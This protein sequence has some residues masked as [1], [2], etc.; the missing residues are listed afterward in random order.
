MKRRS[1]KT[2]AA[3]GLIL[4]LMAAVSAMPD[5][6]TTTQALSVQ[7]D[8]I[9]KVSVPSTVTLTRTGS[10]F[11]PYSG[12]LTLSYKAQ[13]TSTGGGSITLQ[14]TSDFTP[15]GGPS[16]ATGSLTYTCTG[17]GLGTACAG[18]VTASTTAQTTV[19]T[20]PSSGCTGGGG[21]CSAANPATVVVTF[22][23][24]NSP[25]YPTGTYSAQAMFSISA[26]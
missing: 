11:A 26:T 13:T 7:I 25:Q 9:A 1:I 14:I 3:R 21:S 16:A 5:T 8:A 2:R 6:L 10:A 23:L 12:A 17:A 24:D 15:A 4:A 18:S 20:L 19:V 22:S